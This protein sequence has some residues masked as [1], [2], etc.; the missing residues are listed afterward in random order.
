MERVLRQHLFIQISAGNFDLVC[1][2]PEDLQSLETAGAIVF[3][4][5]LYRDASENADNKEILDVMTRSQSSFLLD[6]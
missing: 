3:V 6:I 1:R 5:D 2:F 4:T